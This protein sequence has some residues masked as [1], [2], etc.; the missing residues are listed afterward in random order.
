MN[1]TIETSTTNCIPVPAADPLRS[2]TEAAE[3]WS[4]PAFER[5]D[6]MRPRAAISCRG[7]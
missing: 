5:P 1:A 4:I 7:I 6:T 2:G 3:T